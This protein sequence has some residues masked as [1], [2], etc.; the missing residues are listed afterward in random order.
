MVQAPR[1]AEVFPS[2]ANHPPGAVPLFPANEAVWAVLNPN[3][4][5][6]LRRQ[7][8]EAIDA[9]ADFV[10]SHEGRGYTVDESHGRVAVHQ[11]ATIEPGAHLIGPCL[12]GP[13]A[14]VR[15]AAYVRSWTW[16]CEG[17]IIGH[18]TEVKHSLLLPGAK[19]PHFN[20]VGDSI[21][22]PGVNLGAGVKL[23]NLRHDGGEVHVWL[24]GERVGTGLRKFGAVLGDDV[25]VGC[26]AVTNPGCVLGPAS[27]VDPN[28]TV[29]GVH[30]AAQR[31]R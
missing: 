13:N 18:A 23:S 25:Q 2:L 30:P 9:G 15:H 22:G 8:S 17:S 21:L 28:A 27:S 29:S 3:H 1:P 10:P 24:G 31:H 11:S 5:M 4:A 12:I 7:V 20:Y 14:T 6:A 19:A 26:N 16:A